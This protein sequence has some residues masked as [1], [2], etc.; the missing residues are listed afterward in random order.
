MAGH[1]CSSG[2][3]E[4]DADPGHRQLRWSEIA[5]TEPA[6]D[7]LSRAAGMKRVVA[8]ES[9]LIRR[10]TGGRLEDRYAYLGAFV[11]AVIAAD[12][13]KGARRPRTD[14]HPTFRRIAALAR[15]PHNSSR[16]RKLADRMADH[17][18]R[19]AGTS[20]TSVSA[21]RRVFIGHGRSPLWR[22]LRDFLEGRVQLEMS[23][24]WSLS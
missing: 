8:S 7:A 21:G 1:F 4:A 6:Y 20:P 15:R 19:T 24:D 17:V 11:P 22:E 5:E 9:G 3:P 10:R 13:A 18:N 2:G 12:P 16:P 14:R 23:R